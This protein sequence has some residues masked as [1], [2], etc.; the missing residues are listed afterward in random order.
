MARIAIEWTTRGGR[1]ERG[2]SSLF[3]RERRDRERELAQSPCARRLPFCACVLLWSLESESVRRGGGRAAAETRLDFG[4][5]VQRS[6]YMYY[7]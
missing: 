1:R 2:P 3:S 6:M 5:Q 4:L 7:G